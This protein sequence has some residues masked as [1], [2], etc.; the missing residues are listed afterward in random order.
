MEALTNVQLADQG[1]QAYRTGRYVEAGR[2]YHAAAEA[3]RDAGKPL[4]AAENLNNSGVAYL[5]GGETAAALAEIQD[6]PAAFAALGDTRRQA[7]ALGNLGA[8]LEACGRLDEAAECYR[9]SAQMLYQAG[10]QELALHAVQSLSALQL[11]TGKQLQAL[12]T[13]QAGVE[14]LEKPSPKHRLLKSLLRI[15][16][17]TMQGKSR[18]G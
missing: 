13:M 3:C 12:A 14:K 8:A 7:M 11:R 15:P 2:Y 10:E 16:F 17:E 18:Q 5:Q 4:E 6:T 1:K 9:Q